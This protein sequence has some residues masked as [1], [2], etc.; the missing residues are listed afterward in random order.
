MTNKVDHSLSVDSRPH[1]LISPTH[2]PIL[3][4][5]G[6]QGICKHEAAERPCPRLVLVCCAALAAGGL[7]A[8]GLFQKGAPDDLVHFLLGAFEEASGV[9]LPPPGH[10]PVLHL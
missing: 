8:E 7:A 3:F 2:D 10:P 4:S 9:A 6:A 1:T 5:A